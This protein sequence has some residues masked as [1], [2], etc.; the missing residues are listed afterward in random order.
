MKTLTYKLPFIFALMTMVG[1]V[2]IS[3]LFGVNEDFFK[4]KIT[5]DLNNNKK[6]SAILNS[7]EK[8]KIIGKELSKNWRYYQRFHFHSTGIGAM[9]MS[10]LVFIEVAGLTG[11]GILLS[12]LFIGLGGFFYP[13][14][15]LFAGIYG[16]IMGRHE[17][18]EAFK[19]FGFMGGVFFIGIVMVLF[20]FLRGKPCKDSA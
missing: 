17:A 9:G 5:R 16:P 7:V 8:K 11:F 18:K 10:I 2:F 3:I 13:F 12:R 15:W 6:I 1:G 20:I 4:G 14:V 19:I